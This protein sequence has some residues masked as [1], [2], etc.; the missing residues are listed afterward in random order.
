MAGPIPPFPLLAAIM[1]GAAFAGGDPA[2]RGPARPRTDGPAV[3]WISAETTTYALLPDS[4]PDAATEVRRYLQLALGS[5]RRPDEPPAA[6][7]LVPPGLGLGPAIRLGTLARMPPIPGP[8]APPAPPGA[9]PAR[10]GAGQVRVYWGCGEHIGRGQPLILNMA[11]ARGGA[12]PALAARPFTPMTQPDDQN[13]A[14]SGQWYSLRNRTPL[15]ASASLAGAHR[16][17]GNY[18]PEIRF[19]L[20]PGQDFLAPIELTANRAGAS[21][22]VPL[23]WRPIAGARAYFVTAARYAADGALIWWTSSEAP[24]SNLWHFD[25]L[26]ATDVARLLRRRMLLPAPRPECTVPAEIVGPPGPT[27]VSIVAL[28]REVDLSGPVRPANAPAGWAPS[29]SVKL[30]TRALYSGRLGQ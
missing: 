24:F 12:P 28:G 15:P 26:A 21:G 5:P 22:A 14:T 16:L 19:A 29:W 7:H 6:E 30:R 27:A 20:A 18:I 2:A 9:R 10:P 1:L 17:H 13:A 23:R 11:D 25:Y 3:Y 8:P 4:G